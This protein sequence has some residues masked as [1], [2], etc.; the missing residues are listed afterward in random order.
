MSPTAEKELYDMVK[1]IY[2]HLGL[3]GKRPASIHDIQD[4][5][6]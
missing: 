5:E 2:I 4:T 1:A 3:D 6:V